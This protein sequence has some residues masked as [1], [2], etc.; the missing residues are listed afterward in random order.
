MCS[1][2][3]PKPLFFTG[4]LLL[5]L[6]SCIN[7][8]YDLS[9]GI[10]T[11]ITISEG[12]ISFPLGNTEEI[13]LSNFLKES[14]EI[15]LENGLY[16]I[17]KRG[18]MDKKRIDIDSISFFVGSYKLTPIYIGFINSVIQPTS[19]LEQR[20]T[21]EGYVDIDTRVP[22]EVVSIHQAIVKEGCEAE[23]EI[24]FRLPTGFS[25]KTEVTFTNVEVNFP[26]FIKLN[27]PRAR[28]QVLYLPGEFNPR[29]VIKAEV[30]ISELDFQVFNDGKGVETV[31]ENGETYFRIDTDNTITVTGMVKVGSIDLNGLKNL[32]ITP[33]IS[34][35]N[36]SIGKVRGYFKPEMDVLEEGFHMRLDEEIDFLKEN[37][38]MCIHNPQVFLNITNMFAVPFDLRVRIKAERDGAETIVT[39]PI[40]LSIYGTQE[41]NMANNNFLISRQG[42][43]KEGYRAV[44]AADLDKLF[45]VIPDRIKI[46]IEVMV[47]QSCVH[48]I[49][50]TNQ[51]GNFIS[52]TYQMDLPFEFERI[53]LNYTEA[54]TGLKEELE[55]FADN[56]NDIELHI[57]TRVLNT[58]P[59][60][61]NVS[62]VALDDMG[63]VLPSIKSNM[64]MIAAGNKDREPKVTD[65][66]FSLTIPKGELALLDALNFVINGKANQEETKVAIHEDCFIQL[67]D[68][69]VMLTGGINMDMDEFE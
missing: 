38:T 28:G 41:G 31:K 17:R 32:V 53:D 16:T 35:K 36:L 61:F 55:R 34:V 65:A 48:E 29:E 68:I 22:D 8:D 19:F 42:T 5:C 14:D 43:E 13:R 3:K 37:A 33:I 23:L 66:V 15:Q 44:L 10:N 12:S 54:F 50:L 69:S 64:Q 9:K 1:L 67:T 6:W 18:E 4:C 11:D 52:A 57:S 51:E 24:S 40:V 56:Q 20:L 26:D 60:D 39:D 59:L 30:S 62:L 45:Q 27:D 7:T 58:I 25:N 49:D 47:N 46:N 21:T 2:L 63:E